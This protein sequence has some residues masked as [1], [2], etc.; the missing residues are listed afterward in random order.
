MRWRKSGRRMILVALLAAMLCLLSPLSLPLFGIP[1]TPGVFGVA[2]AAYF[3]PAAQALGAVGLYLGLGA[4]GL[5]VFAGFLGGVGVFVGP[6]G[7]YLLGYLLL[8]AVVAAARAKGRR[9]RVLFGLLSLLP[10]YAAGLFWQSALMDIS[11]WTAAAVLAPLIPLDIAKVLAAEA[12][13]HRLQKR[14][15][16]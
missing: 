5:P 6:T 3:L 16:E 7:G 1:M 12:L 8:V 13:A 2:L 10:C 15:L 14:R 11:F 4:V 9:V